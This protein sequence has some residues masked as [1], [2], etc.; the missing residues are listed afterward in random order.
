MKLQNYH[1]K[2]HQSLPVLPIPLIHHLNVCFAKN[3]LRASI[4]SKSTF[5][6]CILCVLFSVGGVP[7]QV[8]LELNCNNMKIHILPML[9]NTMALNKPSFV[10][11]VMFA[12]VRDQAWLNIKTNIIDRWLKKSSTLQQQP[13]SPNYTDKAWCRPTGCSNYNLYSLQTY[14]KVFQIC[15][16]VNS[17]NTFYSLDPSKLNKSPVLKL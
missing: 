13:P 11:S 14:L 10:L 1:R 9:W 17:T 4:I 15:T 16:C 12:S 3:D 8:S 2:D 5:D 7:M 6:Y